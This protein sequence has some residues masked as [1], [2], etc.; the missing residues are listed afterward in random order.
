MTPQEINVAIAEVCGWVKKREIEPGEW[1]WLHPEYKTIRG[2]G[3]IPDY[4]NDLN[5]MHEAEK[6]LTPEQRD[7]Y[8]DYLSDISAQYN[9]GV[10]VDDAWGTYH[11]TAPQRAEAFLRTVVKWIES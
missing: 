10:R 6:T 9:Q 8:Y 1:V 7:I 4:L 11:A 3:C 2:Q 5:A